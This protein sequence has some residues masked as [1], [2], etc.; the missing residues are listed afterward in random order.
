MTEPSGQKSVL[1]EVS[2]QGN[3]A[4]VRAEELRATLCFVVGAGGIAAAAVFLSG[5]PNR[6]LIDGVHWAPLWGFFSSVT[7]AAACLTKLDSR[8]DRSSKGRGLP[9][10]ERGTGNVE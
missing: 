2:E 8:R 6:P 9:S 3:I 7:M 4:M 5:I 10:E 1:E